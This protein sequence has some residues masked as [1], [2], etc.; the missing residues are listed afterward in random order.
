LAEGGNNG[1]IFLNAI[2]VEVAPPSGVPEPATL[3]RLGI[4]PAGFAFSRRQQ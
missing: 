1:G 2:N 3:A 4:S